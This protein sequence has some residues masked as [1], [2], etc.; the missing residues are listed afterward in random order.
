M[1]NVSSCNNNTFNKEASRSFSSPHSLEPLRTILCNQDS[2]TKDLV[3]L[4]VIL[5]SINYKALVR[6][7]KAYI[8][9]D[10]AGDPFGEKASGLSDVFK[11]ENSLSSA[12]WRL[13]NSNLLVSDVVD[14]EANTIFTLVQG[15][16]DCTQVLPHMKVQ[17]ARFIIHVFPAH[18]E[19]EPML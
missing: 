18:P 7:T 11:S 9:F 16:S 15:V 5:G 4:L 17:A 8:T 12:I 14:A 1:L 13:E 6:A 3:N 2:D 19:L 10:D